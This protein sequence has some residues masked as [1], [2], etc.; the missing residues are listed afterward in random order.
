MIE[1]DVRNNEIVEKSVVYASSIL[2]VNSFIS[3]EGEPV[4]GN[5]NSPVGEVGE[6]M[7]VR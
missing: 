6:D 4:D 7:L 5:F 2:L 1:V 3:A